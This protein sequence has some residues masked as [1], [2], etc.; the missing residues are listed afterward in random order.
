MIDLSLVKLLNIRGTPIKLSLTT[1]NKAN[2]EEEDLRVDFQIASVESRNDHVIDV[3]SAWA[4]KNLTIP[5]KHIK[6]TG[7]VGQ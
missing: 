1:V 5:L 2:T 3:K 7:S 4:V 6:V